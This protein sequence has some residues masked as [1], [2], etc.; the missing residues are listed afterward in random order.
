M[1]DSE[2]QLE[3][4]ENTKVSIQQID[5]YLQLLYDDDFAKKVQGSF[6]IMQVSREPDNLEY[7]IGNEHL[8]NALGRELKDEGRKSMELMINILYVFY[9]FSHFSQFHSIITKFK[10][11]VI[12]MKTIDY[13]EKRFNELMK[14]LKAKNVNQDRLNLMLQKQEKLLYVC[15]HI[16]LNLAENIEIEIKMKEKKIIPSL[17]RIVQYRTNPDLLILAITF[18]KKL[19][20]FQENKDEM[21]EEGLVQNL[22]QFIPHE[23]DQLLTVSLKL[24]LNLTF[25]INVRAYL[26]KNALPQL[27]QLLGNLEHFSIV[28]KILYHLTT[29][30]AGR[31]LPSFSEIIPILMELVIEFPAATVDKELMALVINLSTVPRNSE[32]MGTTNNAVS[33][34]I[35]RCLKSRDNLLCKLMRNITRHEKLKNTVR[36]YLPEIMGLCTKIDDTDVLVEL[37]GVV[38]N[39]GSSAG[40]QQGQYLQI[41][42]K[43][44]MTDF[45]IKN[46]KNGGEQ[47]EDDVLLEVIILVGTLCA[48][49]ECAQMLSQANIVPSL[50]SIFLN[51]YSDEEM[52][53]QCLFSFSQFMLYESTKKQFLTNKQAITVVISMLMTRNDIIRKMTDTVLDYISESSPEWAKIIR[54]RK[55]QL[56]NAAWIRA[57]EEE[58]GKDNDQGDSDDYLRSSVDSDDLRVWTAD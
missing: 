32:L 10:V 6:L 58:D 43:F 17:C 7:L 18:L 19:S 15:F 42:K 53:L 51:K 41:F 4:D 49:K 38:G 36:K 22:L 46:L 31:N 8:L 57:V 25:D 45:L 44:K 20:I 3:F 56:Y 21:T 1:S 50:C 5:D 14:E 35:E 47:V 48:D 24:L 39:L 2:E 23:N 37:L 29:D 13:E 30:E 28:I 34:I 12:V 16:L 52:V 27:L 54:L 33:R 9:S 40:P 11:G 26:A 55:F